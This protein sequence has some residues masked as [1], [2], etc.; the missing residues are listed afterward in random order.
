MIP[1]R[2]RL[3]CSRGCATPNTP[4]A[5]AH[6]ASEKN[7]ELFEKYGVLSRRETLSRSNV[8]YAGYAH[9]IGVE[10][11]ATWQIGSTAILPAAVKYQRNLAEKLRH[12]AQGRTRHASHRDR[13]P[14]GKRKLD[15]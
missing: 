15:L 12:W 1:F 2:L 8:M 9:R 10:A 7:I 14:N 4:A 6:F 13:P 11:L 3:G 5:L